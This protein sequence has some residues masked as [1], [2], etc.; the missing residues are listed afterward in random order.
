MKEKQGIGGLEDGKVR[1]RHGS[2][3]SIEELWRKNR[4]RQEE[5]KEGK[6]ERILR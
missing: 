3:R 6:E 2:M 1:D 4:D 5:S